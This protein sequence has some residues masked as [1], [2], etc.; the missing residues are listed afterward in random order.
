MASWSSVVALRVM[1]QQIWRVLTREV[2]LYVVQLS[3]C[4]Q[5]LRT[6]LKHGYVI[7]DVVAGVHHP[8]KK[9]SASGV[10]R[11]VG[12]VVGEA[13]QARES[14][15]CVPCSGAGVQYH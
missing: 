1:F 3:F 14:L 13:H 6:W 8:G 5:L 4:S 12:E 10:E 11:L 9:L 7:S 2:D 15:L